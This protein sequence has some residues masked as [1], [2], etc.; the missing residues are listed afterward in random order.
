M[1]RKKFLDWRSKRFLVSKS[2]PLVDPLDGEV[3]FW[4]IEGEG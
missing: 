1:S 4:W 2:S 3:S